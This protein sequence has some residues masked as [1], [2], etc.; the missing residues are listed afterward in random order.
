MI[1]HFIDGCVP[2]KVVLHGDETGHIEGVITAEHWECDRCGRKFEED[3]GRC[4]C[5]EVGDG[6]EEAPAGVRP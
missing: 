1:L 6:R 4:R 2:E 5:E 3:P